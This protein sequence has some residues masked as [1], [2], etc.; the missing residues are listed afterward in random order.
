M[1]N[2]PPSPSIKEHLDKADIGKSVMI[3]GIVAAAAGLVMLIPGIIVLKLHPSGIAASAPLPTDP[4]KNPPSGAPEKAP[5]E[6]TPD[7]MLN[8]HNRVVPQPELTLRLLPT[9]ANLAL[10]F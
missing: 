4:T 6:K 5:V 7:R 1:M 2:Q 3:G 10:Q 9:G 8:V